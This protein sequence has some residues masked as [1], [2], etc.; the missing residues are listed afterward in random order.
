MDTYF[1]ISINII[2]FF[3]IVLFSTKIIFGNQ[4][5]NSEIF[6]ICMIA[7]IVYYV[8]YIYQKKNKEHFR[9][10]NFISRN[11][12]FSSDGQIFIK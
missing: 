9:S 6:T 8:L 12:I 4:M 10:N 1:T 2:I 3:L 7:T 11:I 5:N